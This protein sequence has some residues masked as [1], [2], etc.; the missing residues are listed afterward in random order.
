MNIRSAE[1][2]HAKSFIEEALCLA[3]TQ[4]RPLLYRMRRSSAYLIADPCGGRFGP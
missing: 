4:D 3:L 1:N 2:L